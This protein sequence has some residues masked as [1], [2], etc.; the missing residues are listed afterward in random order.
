LPRK[1]WKSI[2]VRDEVYDYFME[3]WRR[4]RT[5]HLK[6]G[7]NELQRFCNSDAKRLDGERETR[8]ETH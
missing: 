7:Y 2:T 5:E 8:K 3:E 6:M 1:G 4:R